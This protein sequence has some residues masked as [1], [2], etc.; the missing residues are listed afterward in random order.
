LPTPEKGAPEFA[1]RRTGR[2][3]KLLG[4]NWRRR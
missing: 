4:G 1:P 3:G 2:L